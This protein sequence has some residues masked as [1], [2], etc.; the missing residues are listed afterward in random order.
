[1][2]LTPGGSMTFRL[3]TIDFTFRTHFEKRIQDHRGKLATVVIEPDH[4]RL[5][6][7]WLTSLLCPAD[8][9]FLEETEVRESV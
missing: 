8:I 7:V 2:N 9:D 3:P 1:L 5:I 6:M 4:D